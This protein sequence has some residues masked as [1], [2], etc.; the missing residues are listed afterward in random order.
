MQPR[1][2]TVEEEAFGMVKRLNRRQYC[3]DLS[4]GK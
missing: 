1:G 2:G 3:I 4:A